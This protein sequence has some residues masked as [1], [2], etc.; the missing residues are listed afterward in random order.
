MKSESIV[1]KNISL[2]DNLDKVPLEHKPI[3][4]FFAECIDRHS[5]LSLDQR[6]QWLTFVAS[7]YEPPG[8]IKKSI[9]TN[10]D[11]S[12]TLGIPVITVE[13]HLKALEDFP[14]FDDLWEKLEKEINKEAK[15]KPELFKSLRTKEPP[16][17]QKTI[18]KVIRLRKQGIPN[19]AIAKKVKLPETRL[20]HLTRRLVRDKK[21]PSRGYTKS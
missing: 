4:K 14:N 3:I 18:A 13:Q 2:K 8:S 21:V 12:G 19:T 10:K 16:I 5:E 9:K 1:S 15:K 17:P 6:E 11:L 7:E 20:D